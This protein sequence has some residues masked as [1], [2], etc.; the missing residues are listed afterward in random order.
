MNEKGTLIWRTVV[1]GALVVLIGLQEGLLGGGGRP[2]V[3]ACLD[4]LLSGLSSRSSVA[5]V[6]TSP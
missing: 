2:G 3:A 5:P 1:A 6:G 4:A